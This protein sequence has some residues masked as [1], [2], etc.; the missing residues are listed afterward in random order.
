MSIG[1]SI[2]VD[3]VDDKL[4]CTQAGNVN[5]SVPIEHHLGRLTARP[6][7]AARHSPS[8]RHH[9]VLTFSEARSRMPTGVRRIPHIVDI[10][11]SASVWGNC[12]WRVSPRRRH[13]PR[14]D[15]H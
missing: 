11:S 12:M 2:S 5:L 6:S 3:D 1:M 14:R 10:Q 7:G 13:S 9:V 4:R 15:L 8:H